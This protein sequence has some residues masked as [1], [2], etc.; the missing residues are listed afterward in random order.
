MKISIVTP[1]YNQAQF[2]EQTILSVWGQEGDFE[3]EHIVMDGGS[4]DKSIDILLKYD[5]LYKSNLF[6]FKCKS[7]KFIWKSR[8]DKGQSDALNKGFAISSGEFLGWLNSDDLFYDNNSLLKVCRAYDRYNTDLVV[9]NVV[10]IDEYKKTIDH[11]I[12]INSLNDREFQEAMKGIGKICIIG[13]PSC[14]FKR[15]VW[16]K[17]GIDNYYYCMDWSLWINAYR[18]GYLFRKIPDYIGCMRQHAEA[19]TVIAGMNKCK[20]VLS[21]FKKNNVWCLNRFYYY[22]YLA[23]LVSQKLP[24]IGEKLGLLM[25]VGKKIRNVLINKHRYY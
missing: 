18:S 8:P 12:L 2:L 7:F 22:I 9:G 21:L 4:T 5:H 24:L 20:E 6:Q 23:L 1:S 14:F 16:E 10:M 15:A 19:K 17:L 25:V 11:P 13:Q 3:L